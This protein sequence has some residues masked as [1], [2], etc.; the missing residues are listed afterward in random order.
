VSP[1]GPP[2]P[3]PPVFR[4]RRVSRRIARHQARKPRCKQARRRSDPP[5]HP[6]SAIDGE[7]ITE[8]TVINEYLDDAFPDPPR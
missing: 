1:A 8:T 3:L 5:L 4:W 2:I 7:I 6:T